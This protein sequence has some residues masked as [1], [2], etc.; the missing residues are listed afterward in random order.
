M[1]VVRKS[2]DARKDR[3]SGERDL[4]FSYVVDI[5]LGTSGSKVIHRVEAGK[6]ERIPTDATY[7]P[8]GGLRLVLDPPGGPATG[9]D[10]VSTTKVAI[11]MISPA[12]TPATKHA[13]L[14]RIQSVMS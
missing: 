1:V 4:R 10:L 5:D 2:F 6:L 3:R 12:Q 11:S 8:T 14:S 9:G 7:D 13:S